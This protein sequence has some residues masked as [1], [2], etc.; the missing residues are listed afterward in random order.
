[1]NWIEN[2][3]IIAGIGL[4][5]F[6]AME[7]QGAMIASIKKKTLVIAC[8][9]VAGLQLL[10][11]FGGYIVC[12][13]LASHGYIADPVNYG[14]IIAVAVLFLLGLRLVIKAIK[15]EFVQESRKDAIRVWD[16]IRII[17]TSSI[18]T[19]AAGCV[20]GLVGT[21]VW[22]MI[23][24]IL[25]ISVVMVIGGLYTGLHFGFEN[26]TFAYVTGAILLWI[27][28]VEILLSSVLA[29]V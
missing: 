21:T 20:C 29:I 16:Y 19:L 1:M 4:D 26:K 11:Y 24:I 14:E 2:L 9:V 22:Q 13:L 18:Y 7:I 23:V 15:R 12:M 3:L 17:V 25:V 28:A 5:I 6:A 27:V 8:A 10:F